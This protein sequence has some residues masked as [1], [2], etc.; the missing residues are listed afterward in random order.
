MALL[1]KAAICAY[2]ENVERTFRL[3]RNFATGVNKGKQLRVLQSAFDKVDLQLRMMLLEV[4]TM[5]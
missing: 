2:Y 1:V 5:R 3:Q 4:H